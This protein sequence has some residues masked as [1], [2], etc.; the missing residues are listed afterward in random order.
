MLKLEE[1]AKKVKKHFTFGEITKVNKYIETAKLINQQVKPYSKI[2][3]LG[4]GNAVIPALLSELGHEVTGVDDLQDPVHTVEYRKKLEK[5]VNNFNIN[6]VVE[7]IFGFESEKEYDAVLMNEIV[8]HL[9]CV[10][11]A[12]NIGINAL[13]TDGVFMIGLPSSVALIKRVNCLLGKTIYPE[14]GYVYYNVGPYRSHIREYTPIEV[15]HLLKYSGLVDIKIVTKN[16]FTREVYEQ[17]KGISKI[18]YKTYALL[19]T[20]PNFRDTILAWGKKPKNWSMQTDPVA[21]KKFKEN[22]L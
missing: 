14:V 22:Y 8:E 7:S 1:A 2:L 6:Y 10:R 20:Y 21:L 17:G 5:F 3:D 19:A 9:T 11:D 4:C 13:K 16:L 18:L 15:K 12:L